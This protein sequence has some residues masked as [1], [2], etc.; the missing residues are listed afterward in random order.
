MQFR[1]ELTP[2]GIMRRKI[3][4]D[5]VTS[6]Q[7]THL[8]YDQPDAAFVDSMPWSGYLNIEAFYWRSL[9]RVEGAAPETRNGI[10]QELNKFFYYSIT[11]LTKLSLHTCYM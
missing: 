3:S 6:Y 1:V 8:V 5:R 7:L 11:N 4:F 10:F 9:G 2:L